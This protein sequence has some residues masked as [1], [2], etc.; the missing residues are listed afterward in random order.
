MSIAA[1]H[2]VPEEEWGQVVADAERF[3]LEAELEEKRMAGNAE[4]E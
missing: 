2:E 1:G 3:R 4:N